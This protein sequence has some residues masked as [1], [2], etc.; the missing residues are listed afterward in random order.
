MIAL[1][2]VG[3]GE[4]PGFQIG[5]ADT[6]DDYGHPI[7]FSSPRDPLFRVECTDFGGKCPIAGDRLRIPNRARPAGGSDAHLAVIDQ[8]RG[9]EYDFWRVQSKPEGGMGKLVV[10]WGGRTRIGRDE[11]N[12]RRA[13]ATAAEFALSAG[14]IRAAELRARSIDHALFMVVDCTN[15][16]SVWPA[17]EG[18]GSTCSN[19]TAPAMGQHFYL[20]MTDREI[21]ALPARPWQRTILRAMAE[22]GMFVGDTGGVGWGIHLESSSGQTSFGRPDPWVKLAKKYDLPPID[23]G[24][25][26]THYTFDLVGLVDWGRE[27]RVAHPCVSHGRC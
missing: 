7:Y 3:W 12:G 6:G 13:G 27:L 22:Y 11:G 17:G 8:D 15:G 21:D 9:W 10:G 14:I 24:G 5:T 25:G 16:S 2:V 18:A 23:V 4:G 20:Q 1:T 19:P 26:S